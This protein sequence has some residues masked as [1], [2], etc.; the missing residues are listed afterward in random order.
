[1]TVLIRPFT[2]MAGDVPARCSS[3]CTS[4]L[5][6]RA[7]RSSFWSGPAGS[8]PFTRSMG[9]LYGPAIFMWRHR[10]TTFSSVTAGRWCGGGRHRSP[11]P[12]RGRRPWPPG[13]RDGVLSGM[14]DHGPAGLHAIARCG[15]LTVVQKP[16]DA[17][18]PGMPSHA[19]AQ[20]T[21]DHVLPVAADARSAHPPDRRTC[22]LPFAVPVDI[23]V[24]AGIA[25]KE[26][27]SWPTIPMRPVCRPPCPV[28]NVPN[29][30]VG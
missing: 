10:T 20:N 27:P 3:S 25:E 12:F 29:A 13:D 6:Q 4:H 14:L 23:V 8:R 2:G 26:S 28:P 18:W 22:A 11:V 5:R 15:G 16:A 1:M 19:I 17:E 30:G 9:S 7:C 21:I 24:E